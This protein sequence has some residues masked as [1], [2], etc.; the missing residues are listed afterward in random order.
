MSTQLTQEQVIINAE[1][2]ILGRMASNIVKLLKEGRNIVIVN[3]EKA[4]ISG[5]KNMVVN[6]Y[7]L[8]FNVRTLFNPYKNG[9]RRPR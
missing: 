5:E 3:A 2:Q 4:V 1:G 9:I 8:L 7:K 6:S